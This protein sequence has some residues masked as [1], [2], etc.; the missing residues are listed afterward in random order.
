MCFTNLGQPLSAWCGLEWTSLSLP[1]S[2]WV[3]FTQPHKWAL[4][5]TYIQVKSIDLHRC[6][7]IFMHVI[8]CTP[9]DTNRNA[10][11]HVSVIQSYTI[12]YI[13]PTSLDHTLIHLPKVFKGQQKSSFYTFFFMLSYIQLLWPRLSTQCRGHTS[14]AVKC[15]D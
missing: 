7:C 14:K 12:S 9:T 8:A 5:H 10:W 15:V 1:L 13:F 3:P 4:S 6:I 11:M 2:L